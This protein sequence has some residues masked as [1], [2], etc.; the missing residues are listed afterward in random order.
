MCGSKRS[1]WVSWPE[2]EGAIMPRQKIEE[3]GP[4]ETAAPTNGQSNS[5]LESSQLTSN[6]VHM[7]ASDEDFAMNYNSGPEPAATAE[8][9]K[10]SAEG[11]HLYQELKKMEVE[12]LVDPDPEDAAVQGALPDEVPDVDLLLPL[13][14]EPLKITTDE[15]EHDPPVRVTPRGRRARANVLDDDEEED[16]ERLAADHLADIDRLASLDPTFITDP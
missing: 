11:E 5:P 15:S 7:S 3:T 9:L 12:S 1:S 2:I 16:E 8:A 10:A 13:A 6:G 14:E 4:V